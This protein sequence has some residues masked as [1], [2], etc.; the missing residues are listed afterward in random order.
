MNFILSRD[1]GGDIVRKECRMPCD[2]FHLKLSSLSRRPQDP[3]LGSPEGSIRPGA[4]PAGVQPRSTVGGGPVGSGS[5]CR[6][7]VPVPVRSPSQHSRRGHGRFGPVAAL[8][9]TQ[10]HVPAA[11][12]ESGGGRGPRVGAGRRPGMTTT[13]DSAHQGVSQTLQ[14]EEEV[15]SMMLMS[16]TTLKSNSQ[17][18]ISWGQRSQQGL[19]SG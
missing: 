9:R 1:K 14:E 5:V 7:G 10:S 19:A 3:G 16:Q 4:V 18:E 11:P 2:V 8:R 6:V 12:A 17:L 15:G 13:G